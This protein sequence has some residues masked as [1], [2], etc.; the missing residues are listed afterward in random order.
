MTSANFNIGGFGDVKLT[1]SSPLLG[2]KA[3]GWCPEK[4]AAKLNNAKVNIKES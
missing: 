3:W 4:C 2:Y 1:P